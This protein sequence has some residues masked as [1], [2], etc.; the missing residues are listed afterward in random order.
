MTGQP[1]TQQPTALLYGDIDLNLL[2]GSAIWVQSMA[3]A[4]ARAGC[5]VTLALKSPVH[6]DRLVAPLL[7]EPGVT[8]RRTFEERLLRGLTGTGLSPVQAGRVLH[9]LDSEHRYDLVVLRGRRVLSEV[10]TH[11]IFDGRLW[12]YLTDIPQSVHEM[13]ASAASGLARI[14]A[15]SRYLLCQTEELRCFL[16]GNVPEAC[17][18]C[19]LLLPIVPPVD[20]IPSRHAAGASDPVGDPGGADPGGADPGGA[21]PGGADPGGADPG[22]ADPG[23]G[24]PVRLVYTGKFAPRWNTY[25]MTQLPRLLATRGIPAEIHMVG[26]KIHDDHADPGFSRRMRSALGGTPL[27]NPSPPPKNGVIWHGGQPRHEAMRIAASCDIGLSWRNPSLDASLELSTKVLEFGA[28]GLPVILNRTPMH[29]ALLGIDYPMF[30][31]DLRDVADAV[32]NVV[33]DRPLFQ[34]AARRTGYAAG[35][36]TMDQAVQRLRGYLS[37]AV[38]QPGPATA[39]PATAVPKPAATRRKLRVG[40]AGH[41][42]KFFGQLLDYLRRL[43]D[44]EVRLDQWEALGKHDADASAELAGWADVVICEWC[45]PNAIWY[46]RHKRQG[47][48][49]LVRLHRFELYSR[50]PGQVDIGA[51]DQVICVSRYYADLCRERTGWPAAKVV[52]VPNAVDIGQLDR[53]KLDGARFNLGMIGVGESRKRLDLGLDVLEELRRD[54]DRYMLYVKSKMPWE[55]WWIWQKAEE[56]DHITTALH[57]IQRSPLLRGAVV[58]DEAGPDVPMWLRRVGFVLS[59]SDDES[60]HVAPVEGMASRAVPVVRHWAGA[61]TVY[62][63][64]WLHESTSEMAEAIVSTGGADEWRRAGDVAH[65]QAAES[66]S[67][68]KVSETWGRLLTANLPSAAGGQAPELLGAR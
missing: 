62:D 41:D 22:G 2:D 36:F 31:R 59:T 6:T 64:R 54:D 38:P 39:Q 11:G 67:V 32:A 61:E 23:G 18:K 40:V 28:L 17:G 57:R 15:A 25:E 9:A 8:V 3:Q 50:Y 44:V 43:P 45:G 58:F 21:D 33:A 34:L 52:T 37:Q 65:A 27:A 46:S 60:F 16:E 24:V 53:P 66:F 5:A 14:A 35:Q 68:V 56:R 63:A 4:L 12:T 10:T 42:L 1:V 51:V 13:T 30:A 7:A 26:D 20:A 19:V 29:E 55:H 49:L 48:R 47:T